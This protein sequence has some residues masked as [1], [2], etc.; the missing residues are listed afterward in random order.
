[1][2]HPLV[3]LRGVSKAFGGVHAVEDVSLTLEPGEVVAVLGHNGAGKSTLMKLL[4]GAYRRDAGSILVDGQDVELATPADAYSLGI[5]TIHQTLAL[6]DNLDAAANL[7]LGREIAWRLGPFRVMDSQRMH[8]VATR[9][10][11]Q[12]NPRFTNLNTPSRN[13]SGGQRQTIAIARAIHFKARILIM[14]EPTAALGPQETAM[15]S[16]LVRRLKADG[17]GIFLISHD[18]HD[19]FD[20]SDRVVVMKNG[21]VVGTARTQ[22][23]TKDEVLGMIILGRC[24]PAAQPGPGAI[25]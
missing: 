12:L 22:E 5:E 14:D 7:F 21:Q 19:V 20:L 10:I 18:I 13:L 15:V 3:E 25:H 24:P 23:V 1:M 17:L 8:D 9:V 2:H 6:A 4:A 16:D 11:Q